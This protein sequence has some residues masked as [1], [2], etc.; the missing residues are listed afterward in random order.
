LY[1]PNPTDAELQAVVAAINKVKSAIPTSGLDPYTTM[2]KDILTTPIDPEL[3]G[4][5]VTLESLA[6]ETSDSQLGFALNRY[7]FALGLPG[8][9]Q[10]IINKEFLH[11]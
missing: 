11:Q 10:T 3:L 7:G 9:I 8:Q 1:D 2:L 6:A 5:S 4:S